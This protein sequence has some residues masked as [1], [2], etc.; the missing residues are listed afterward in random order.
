MA[1][2]HRHPAVTIT[3]VRDGRAALDARRVSRPDLVIMDVRMPRMDGRE[4]LARIRAD[5]SLDELPVVMLSTSGNDED[6]S[7][8]YRHRANAYVIKSAGPS[9]PPNPADSRARPTA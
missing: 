5:A 6:V 4:T 3:R 8:C 2:G 7:Y 9:A 1:G